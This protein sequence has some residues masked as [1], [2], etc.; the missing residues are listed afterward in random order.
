[1][2]SVF[3]RELKYVEEENETVP[4]NQ[5]FLDGYICKPPLYRKTPLGRE[6]A[7]V[8][9]VYKRQVLIQSIFS[10]LSATVLMLMRCFT[11]TFS[12]TELSLIHI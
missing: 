12:D 6:I 8:L 10:L 9:D 1:M 5:I 7:D 4:V 11:P 2:L 3:S